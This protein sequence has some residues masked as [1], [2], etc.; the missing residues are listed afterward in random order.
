[1]VACAFPNGDKVMVSFA[2]FPRPEVKLFRL[3]W[4]GLLPGETLVTLDPGRAVVAWRLDPTVGRHE[5]ST[6]VLDRFTAEVMTCES[7]ADVRR[8]FAQHVAVM[9]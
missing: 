8:M 5:L 6:A 3:K 9:D 7:A 1:M 2:G 4:G